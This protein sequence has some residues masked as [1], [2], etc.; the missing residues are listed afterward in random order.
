MNWISIG[1]HELSMKDPIYHHQMLLSASHPAAVVRSLQ[2]GLAFNSWIDRSLFPQPRKAYQGK[3]R[4]RGIG[5][6][7]HGLGSIPAKIT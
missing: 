6:V 5:P 7:V 4:E 1:S 2:H 3:G